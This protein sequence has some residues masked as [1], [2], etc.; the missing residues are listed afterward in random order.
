MLTTNEPQGTIETALESLSPV[1]RSIVFAHFIDGDPIGRIARTSELKRADVDN[2]I[3]TALAKMKA[4][5]QRKGVRSI[6]DVV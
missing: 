4:T 1:E 2:L 5:L 3:G 6:V